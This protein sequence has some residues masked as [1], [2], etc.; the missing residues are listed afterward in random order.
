MYRIKSTEGKER[1]FRIK[2]IAYF[3]AK[4]IARRKKDIVHIKKEERAKG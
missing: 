2:F 1:F 4:I 3:V